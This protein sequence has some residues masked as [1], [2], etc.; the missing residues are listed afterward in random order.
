MFET[1]AREAAQVE[2]L[3]TRGLLER[4]RAA[5]ATIQRSEAE[6]LAVAYAWA[7]SHPVREAGLA[8][9][10]RDASMSDFEPIAGPGCPEVDEFA[11]AELGAVLS[12]S[13]TAAKRLIGN[14]LE[15]RHRLPRL[16]AGV[17]TGTVSVW[18]ARAVAEATSHASVSLSIE[19]AGWVDA[20]VATVAGKVGAAQLERTVAEA[21]K[22]YDLAVPRAED[23]PED[24]W[25]HVDPRHVTFDDDIHFAGTMQLTAELDIADALDLSAAVGRGA[26]ELKEFGCD[27][28]LA[29]RRSMALGLLAR[30]QTA[31]SLDAATAPA[32]GATPISATTSRARRLDLHVHV[33]ATLGTDDTAFGFAPTATLD[34]GQRLVLLSQVKDWCR[35][36]HTEVRIL[37]V[38]NLNEELSTTGYT[39]SPRLRRQVQLR[40]LTCVFPWCTRPARACDLDHVTPYDH[41]SSIADMSPPQTRTGNLA[42]LCR[43][44]HRLKTHAGW[45]LT[46]P[47]SGVF[48][49]VSPHGHRFRRDQSGT[50]PGVPDG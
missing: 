42:C 11:P 39:P 44:H 6:L 14:A 38:I 21:I 7:I 41:S 46:S 27:A 49:W 28:P 34:E 9:T 26:R 10:F 22:R 16:W 37:P 24:G 25:Q 35:D 40:D 30:Q 45:Q 12:M 50:T 43:H 33:N 19:A 29:A 17:Q 47:A 5:H 32:V 4:A 31:L 36:T 48:D 8:A 18:R 3:S 15:L 23:D 2:S 1:L 20:Q 13:T